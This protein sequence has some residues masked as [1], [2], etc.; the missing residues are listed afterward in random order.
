[1]SI[2]RYNYEGNTNIGFY[3]T[4]TSDQSILPPDFKRSELFEGE[5]VETFIG[6]TRLVGLFTAGNSS[7]ILVP[8]II[9][10]VEKKKLDEAEI[11][12]T[13]IDTTETAIGNLVLAND[14][15]AVISERIEEHREEIE[16]ALDVE[17]TVI[18]IAGNPTPGVCGVANNRGA[19]IHRDADEETA[20]KV[21]EA[22]RVE[23]I[24]IGTTNMGSPYT[25]SGAVATDLQVLVGEE[26][27]GPEIGRLDRTLF[28]H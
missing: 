10:R 22:L 13:V 15:G 11:D 17:A 9:T 14:K 24:D 19:V 16:E 26:T 1:M 6:R 28:E 20:E 5:Q 4:V 3:A 8:D 21:K 18:N 7:S 27:T 23:D 2:D 25:G 12:Y